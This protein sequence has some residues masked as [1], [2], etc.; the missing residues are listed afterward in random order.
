MSALPSA[1][2][3]S[4]TK[5]RTLPAFRSSPSQCRRLVA[6]ASWR[7]PNTG[8]TPSQLLR[9][10]LTGNSSNLA[11]DRKLSEMFLGDWSQNSPPTS[12]WPP[13]QETSPD[14]LNIPAKFMANLP[15]W[16]MFVEKYINEDNSSLWMQSAG[17]EI[18]EKALQQS[19]RRASDGE[20]LSALSAIISRLEGLTGPC[21]KRI[22]FLSMYY[23]VQA[24]S[25]PALEKYMKRYLDVCSELL[26]PR[27]SVSLVN[28]FFQA[29]HSSTFRDPNKDMR[30]LLD[31]VEG[32]NQRDDWNLH[33]I[34]GN[35]SK[36]SLRAREQYIYLLVKLGNKTRLNKVYKQV[37]MASDP[38]HPD[39]FRPIYVCVAALVDMGRVRTAIRF[40]EK[41]SEHAHGTLPGISEFADLNILLASDAVAA[42]IPQLLGE[43]EYRKLLEVQI[44]HMEDRLGIRWQSKESNHTSASDSLLVSSE[45]PLFTIEGDNTGYDSAGRFFAEIKALGCSRSVADLRRI[46]S[47]LEDREGDILIISLPSVV[48]S[49]TEY[50]WCPQP[51]LASFT[52]VASF[53]TTKSRTSSALGLI[54]VG[55]GDDKIPRSSERFMHLMSLGTVVKRL[56]PSDDT[57][58]ENTNP[59]T[60]TGHLVAWD[61]VNGRLFAI[62][63]G[64][65]D[66]AI[67]RRVRP[68]PTRLS[69]LEAITPIDLPGH[70]IL[71]LDT[72][73]N[74]PLGTGSSRYHV[75][76]DPGPNLKP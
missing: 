40:L 61:R 10:A 1:C 54:R 52:D 42:I 31:V 44:T 13:H 53:D 11:G 36:H 75:N 63:V 62:F 47:L 12:L 5:R 73:S 67:E 41:A 59:W 20:I 25:A 23:A 56:K 72:A 64:R 60:E 74:P 29:L 3:S 49:V 51:F 34:C 57:N 28:A 68:P 8:A 43:E 46:V 16:Q 21:S 48:D 45:K 33:K 30:A 38:C 6:T 55:Y 69:G 76:L 9:F 26:D 27:D 70:L 14:R 71:P 35:A 50:A 24:L 18:L 2:L 17:F 22:Y 15:M 65:I 19:Q 4:L 37:L 32:F 58:P 66:G 39:S 7:P